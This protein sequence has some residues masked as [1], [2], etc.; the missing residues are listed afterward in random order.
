MVGVLVAGP[1]EGRFRVQWLAHIEADMPRGQYVDPAASRVSLSPVRREVAETT[2]ESVD[3]AVRGHAIPYLGQ[4]PLGS[5]KPEHI[6]DWLSAL[7]RNVAVSSYRRVIYNNDNPQCGCRWRTLD[8]EPVP[9]AIGSSSRCWKWPRCAMVRRAGLRRA[10]SAA[11]ALS[12]HGR[13][14]RWMRAAA[15]RD[16]RPPRRWNQLLLGKASHCEPGEGDEEG[17]LVRPA[18]TQQ[19]P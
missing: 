1:H 10:G 15:R 13:P 11:G 16:L 3:S 9:R 6:R 17:A 2:R 5:F 4:R 12:R 19:S 18:Q 8:Q 7:E 14:R